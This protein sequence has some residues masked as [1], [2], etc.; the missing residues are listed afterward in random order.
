MWDFSLSLSNS[1][2]FSFLLF[3]LLSGCRFLSHSDPPYYRLF[4][5]Y[6]GTW[7]I[8][9]RLGDWAMENFVCVTLKFTWSS[10]GLYNILR[11][12]THPIPPPLPHWQLIGSQFSV[13]FFI[14][15]WWRPIS[16]SVPPEN[17]VIPP[18][19][20]PPKRWIMTDLIP[21]TYTT[22]IIIIYRLVIFPLSKLKRISINECSLYKCMWNLGLGAG[23]EITNI[24][25]FSN[26][27]ISSSFLCL[28]FRFDKWP[29]EHGATPWD[30]WNEAFRY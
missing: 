1:S 19:T 11:R 22:Y 20:P 18:P 9:C 10:I 29:S 30:C 17:H 23:G 3:L 21:T 12:P 24:R 6:V 27:F 14:L 25:S 8:I 2:L 5:T 16:P 28:T 4:Y 13:A 7:V 15:C 26:L